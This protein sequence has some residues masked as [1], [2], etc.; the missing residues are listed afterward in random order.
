MA[1]A[2]T[3]RAARD[4]KTPASP[5]AATVTSKWRRYLADLQTATAEPLPLETQ[6]RLVRVTGLVLEAAGIRVP[7]G[8]V[9][10]I[11]QD[12]RAGDASPPV[13]A[14]VVGF[15]GDCAYLMPT[16]DVHGLASGARVVPRATPAVAMKLGEARHPWRRHLDRTLHL[17]VGDGLLG[18][19][20]DAHG[21][22]MDRKGPIVAVHNEPLAHRPVRRHR[23][24]RR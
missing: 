5:G 1:D 19:V 24:R 8:S 3:L 10:E 16:G 14:E 9:C 12:G 21:A 11:H 15:S 18:R 22:P 4:D 13:I 20:V 6:G 17:P 7:V 23:R 2:E